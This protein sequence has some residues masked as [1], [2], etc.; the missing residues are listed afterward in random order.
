MYAA[1]VGRLEVNGPHSSSLLQGITVCLSVC[2]G[3][4]GPGAW[5][6]QDAVMQLEEKERELAFQ[7]NVS[8][9]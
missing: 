9:Y 8:V 1:A 3:R 6:Q 2:R 4:G 5:A 7:N